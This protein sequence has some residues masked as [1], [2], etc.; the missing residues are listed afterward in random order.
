MD[1]HLRPQIKPQRIVNRDKFPEIHSE[2]FDSLSVICG[3]YFSIQK[4]IFNLLI[5]IN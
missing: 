4:L 5:T 1:L 2:D 3:T